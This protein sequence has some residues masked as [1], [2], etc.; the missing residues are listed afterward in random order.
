[1]TDMESRKFEDSCKAAFDGAEVNPSDGVWTNIELDLEKSEGSRTRRSLLFYKMLA[2]ASLLF[3]L[4]VAGI[5]YYSIRNQ[6]T[7]YVL[8]N[9]DNAISGLAGDA[10][11]ADPVGAGRA[12]EDLQ[13][14]A[15]QRAG[16][17][18]D[19]GLASAESSTGQPV[20]PQ[21]GQ[22]SGS[23]GH[24]VS[25]FALQNILVIPSEPYLARSP[26]IS[27]SE[28]SGANPLVR[29][30]PE[31]YTLKD[32]EPLFDEEEPD[33]GALLLAQLAQEEM[34]YAALDKREA[35]DRA[36]RIWTSVGFAAGGFS[37]VNSSV[38]SSAANSLYANNSSTVPDK[39]AKASGVAYSFG[40]TVGAKLS[41]RWILQGGV[42]YLTQSSDYIATNVVGDNNFGTLKAESINELDKLQSADYNASGRLAPTFPYSVNNSVQFFSLPVQA[43]YLILNKKFSLQLNAGVSTDLFL[44]NTI[45]PEGGSLE[46]TTQGSGADSPYRAVNFS[47]LMGT[48][49]SYRFGQH[50]RVAL[51][52]GLRYPLNSVYKTDIGIQS[53]PLT[54]DVGL[55]FRYIF[56]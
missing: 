42:N 30:L 14:N 34:E 31:L 9:T 44:Q 51:N 4:G 22:T 47:G 2:A 33:P 28:A 24:H 25:A 6:D 21:K 16:E 13:D 46:K 37:S 43:G 3:A 48:E 5:G 32:D 45:T 35:E 52:P 23:N 15:G 20:E 8:S 7:P 53:T 1:M 27:F 39:Q 55:R 26:I 49:L 10:A 12:R 54:F 56:H 19:H 50:Y 36:E 40:I 11:D 18:P 38:S 29:K 41:S 17:R